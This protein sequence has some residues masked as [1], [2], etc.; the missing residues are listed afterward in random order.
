MQRGYHRSSRCNSFQSCLQNQLDCDSLNSEYHK[1]SLKHVSVVVGVYKTMNVPS[2]GNYHITPR[3]SFQF[4][5]L[6]EYYFR[7]SD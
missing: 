4:S 3:S 2:Y 7:E 6:L 1:V 5:I